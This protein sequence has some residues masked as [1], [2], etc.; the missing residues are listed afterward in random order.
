LLVALSTVSK[1]LASME[2]AV[3][4]FLLFYDLVDDYMARRE[5]FRHEHLAKGW[6]AAA[7]GELVLGGALSD[8]ADA[9]VLLFKGDSPQAAKAFAA[10]DPYVVNGLVKRWRVRQW[11]TVIGMEAATPLGARGAAEP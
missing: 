4:H 5:A 1:G 2:S 7:R 3:K 8:P 10:T 9:A 6:A 11:T